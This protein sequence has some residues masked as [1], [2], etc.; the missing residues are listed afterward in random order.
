VIHH[1]ACDGWSMQI[2]HREL[3]TL[4]TAICAGEPCPLPEL[5]LQYADFAH[6]QRQYLQGEV[7]QSQLNY[8]HKQLAEASPLLELPTDKP[9]P[10]VQSFRGRSEFLELNQD[11]TLKLK[12][13]SQESGTTLFMTMLAVFTLLLSRYSGQESIVVGSAIANRNRRETQPLIGFFVNTLALRTN[14]QGNPTFLELLE[15]VKQVT[16]DAYDHQDLPFEKLVDELG[17]E[18]SLSHHPLF[19]VAFGLQNETQEKLEIPGLT[20]TRLKWENTT[21]LFDLSLMFRETPQGLIGEWEYATDLFEAKTIQRMTGH[22]AVL[23]QGIIDNPQQPINTLPLLTKAERQQL[24]IWNQTNSDYPDNQTLVDLFEAQV[25]KTPNNLALV[26][27]DQRLTYQQLNQLANQLAHYLIENHKIKPDTLIGICVERSLEMVIGLLGILKAGGA[28][29]PIDPSYPQERIGLM[30]EDSRTSVLLTQSDL[31]DQ[32]PLA[33]LENPPQVIC[34]DEAN[35]ASSLTNNPS[36]QSTPDNLAYVIYTSGSTGRP[37]GVM[38]EHQGLTNLASS[39]AKT[40]QIQAQSRLLQFASFSFDISVAEIAPTLTTGACLY[41]AKKETLLPSQGLVNFLA[42][43]KISHIILPPSAL[44]V[45]PQASLPDLQT[46]AVGGEA[47]PIELVSQWATGRRFFNGYGP[48]ESTVGASIAICEPNGKKPPIGKP[49]SNVRIYILDAHNQPLPPG[50]PGELCIAG[51]GLARGYLN[52]PETT[53]EKFI[54][55]DLFDQTER[56]YKTGDLARWGD[57]GNIEYLGRIDD[58][59]KLRGFR[60]ELGEIE[61]LLLQHPSVKE[62]VVILYEADNNPRLVAY[63]TAEKSANSEGQLKDYLKIRL[64]NYMVPSQIML[65]DKLPLTPNGKLDRRALPV[66]DTATD[67]FQALVTPTE[68]LLAT[69]WQSLLKAKSVGRTDNF[70][71][72]GGHSLLATQ[73]VARIRDTFGVELPVRKVF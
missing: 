33:E 7:L 48:T 17:K 56:I 20:L 49:L 29:V 26:F 31:L 67:N 61:S 30:L 1:I 59:I 11:L 21:T 57:D 66:P 2:L 25:C 60:I 24:Q 16:L 50:I 44:A 45:L 38:I 22:F 64:P 28:Y 54:E 58:Q 15:R 69:L 62:A 73:L 32:L 23:L 3:F 40:F 43:H 9:R 72:L 70:F 51:V 71:E 5:L 55:I 41:L 19:Q 8:W 4:Y 65:L 10:S 12:R 68:E 37:K 18:R 6:W 36:P 53:A 14:L 34:L 13:L 47:C 39:V 27:E 35:F 42:D 46:I 52:R 63:L